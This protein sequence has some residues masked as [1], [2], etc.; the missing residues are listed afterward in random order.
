MYL[1]IK[2]LHIVAVISWMAG[3]LYLPRLFVYHCEAETGSAQSE[4]FKIMEGRLL[5]A[6]MTPAMFAAWASGLWMASDAG[7]YHAAWLHAKLSLVV[8]MTAV[9]IHFWRLQTAFAH[10]SNHHAQ[11]YYR[12]WNEAPTALMLF[13]VSFVVLKP[14]F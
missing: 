2:T 3:L 9:H 1:W 10:D 5:R 13:I 8:A 12:I 6:I 4:T 11:R 7:F 14:D